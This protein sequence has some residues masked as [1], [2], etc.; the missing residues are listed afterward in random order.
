[1]KE[2]LLLA[3]ARCAEQLSDALLAGGAL[4]VSLEDADAGAE[5]E[6]P[7]FGE[8]GLEPE[9]LAW[10]HNRLAVLLDDVVEPAALIAAACTGIGIEPLPI[11]ALRDVATQDW[12]RI[13][14][15]QFL[16]TQIGARLW[17]V[18]SWH[19]P[20]DPSAVVLRLDPALIR[21]RAYACN[22][23]K[24]TCNRAAACST[25]AAARASWRLPRRCSAPAL[26]QPPTST[27][28]RSRPRE[29]MRRSMR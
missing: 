26:W 3:D 18:P 2:V 20:P 25:M 29:P 9:Q 22:G 21:P 15:S 11:I 8:P 6:R 17:I 13:T 27:R 12:V 1:V 5:A 14:Q 10:H 19:T 24:P 7:L 23:S 4:S 28:R 16:P